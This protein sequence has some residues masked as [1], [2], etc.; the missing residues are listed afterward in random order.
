[1][2]DTPADILNLID[3]T[4]AVEDLG[5]AITTDIRHWMDNRTDPRSDGQVA[6]DYILNPG[7]V[8]IV[9]P[10]LIAAGWRPPEHARATLTPT[11]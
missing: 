9:A 4:E 3:S 11:S 7:N 8:H 6:V 10:V 1:V 5:I 2:I